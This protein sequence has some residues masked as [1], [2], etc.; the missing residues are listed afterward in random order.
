MVQQSVQ[1]LGLQPIR[2]FG[3]ARD[4]REEDGQLFPATRDFDLLLSSEN[5]LVY[6]GREVFRELARELLQSLG[7]VR[8]LALTLLQL[9]DVRV[10][11]YR[12]TV[13]GLALAGQDPATIAALLD[14]WTARFSVTGHALPNPVL[15][16]ALG[17]LDIPALGGASHDAFE[18][19]TGRY[20]YG[21]PRIEQ[22]SILVVAHHQAILAIV[23]REGLGDAV[24][25]DGQSLAALANLPLGP[26]LDL[27]S[28][29]PED[30]ECLGHSADLVA[31][32]ATWHVNRRVARGEAA[33]RRGDPLD[34]PHHLGHH[35]PDR[36]HGRPHHT[37][38]G[39]DEKQEPAIADRVGGAARRGIAAVLGGQDQFRRFLA[40]TQ[41]QRVVGLQ[42][43]LGNRDLA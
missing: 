8:Q 38:T 11:C 39:D 33:H 19:H 16:P 3:E 26:P 6:L 35:I 2:R 24:D 17:L 40:E 9:R 31:A 29:V 28:R 34:R 15:D 25:R 12:A 14:V 5:R 4:V 41:D 7:F 1:I 42:G 23:E 43:R 37:Q 20:L 30:A 21:A 36:D 18:R 32:V 22:R 27:D 13:V 10:D